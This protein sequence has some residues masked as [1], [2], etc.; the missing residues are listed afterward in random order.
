MT[1]ETTRLRSSSEKRARRLVPLP[2]SLQRRLRC[3]SPWIPTWFHTARPNW[4]DLPRV[5]QTISTCCAAC[6]LS[7]GGCS[8]QLSDSW[9][10]GCAELTMHSI[11][12]RCPI[13]GRRPQFR[14]LTMVKFW[15]SLRAF[16]TCCFECRE[17]AAAL[18]SAD[19]YS[20]AAHDRLIAQ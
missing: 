19:I 8:G 11:P 5:A 15:H 4:S 20:R 2:I 14:I 3:S 12:H 6:A 1:K 7:G 16:T 10:T 18:L 9:R 13:H 17:D